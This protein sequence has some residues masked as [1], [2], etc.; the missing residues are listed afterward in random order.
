MRASFLVFSDKIRF[1][2]WSNLEYKSELP[3][4]PIPGATSFQPACHMPSLAHFLA[5]AV[6]VSAPSAV[7]AQLTDSDRMRLVADIEAAAANLDADLFP[8]LDASKAELLS[9][10]DSAR[11]FFKTKTSPENGDAWLE[12]L[13][14]DPLVEQIASDESPTSMAR[15][16]IDLRFRLV[17]IVPGLEIAELLDLRDSVEGLIQAIRFRER[18]KSKE[19]LS[20]QLK[21][22]A[23]HVG[24]LDDNPS[25]GDVAAISTLLSVLD[26]S[27]QANQLVTSLRDTFS[28]PNLVISVGE[29]LVQTVVN[30]DIQQI[31]PV[32]DCILGTRI[33]GKAELSGAVTANVHPAV[34]AA[35]VD[36]SL[37]A[38]IVSNN[39]GYNGPVRLRTMGYGDVSVTQTMKVNDAGVVLEPADTNASLETD[40]TR[41][42]HRLSIVRNI[43]RRRAAQQ[44]PQA[45]RIALVRMRK[46][47]ESQFESQIKETASIGTPKFLAELRPVLKRMS[48][49]EPERQWSSTEQ[50]ILVDLTFRRSDQLASVVSPPPI[51]TPYDAAI[52]I[53]ESVF[54]NAFAPVFAGRTYTED[55]I[56]ELIK[57]SGRE[58]P[59]RERNENG[60]FDPPFEIDFSSRQPI[61]LEARGQVIRMGIRGTRFAQGN[62]ELKRPMEITALYE[63]AETADGHAILRRK[64]DVDVSF[65][66]KRLTVSQAGIKRTVQKKFSSFFP[67]VVLDRP[68]EVPADATID[69]IRGR[70]F[71]VHSVDAR[72]GWLTIT[73]H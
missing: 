38:R 9:R 50:A 11:R 71:R 44:K 70:V 33:F 63:P 16:A 40:I 12:Y 53:H 58:V 45:D 55:R 6:A 29:P 22:L 14:L 65:G 1:R 68:L 42:E 60:E 25:T 72:D 57:K 64:G 69:S 59:Q 7:L 48:L 4:R 10:V 13:A 62:R 52:Q 26:T 49:V 2:R 73:F 27:G 39:L 67:D 15:E 30:Q 46:R 47:V 61:V 17:G 19:S 51:P 36:L 20:T 5:I 54:D 35:R 24:Q 8:D 28:R 34:G 23:Q 37:V 31:R 56:M 3:S 43:A 32:R 66:S 41:I 21:S 18:E